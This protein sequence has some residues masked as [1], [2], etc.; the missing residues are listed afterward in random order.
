MEKIRNTNQFYDKCCTDN[1]SKPAV[2]F[3]LMYLKLI[4]LKVECIEFLGVGS[5]V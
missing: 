3:F 1:D 5:M 2:F 4:S